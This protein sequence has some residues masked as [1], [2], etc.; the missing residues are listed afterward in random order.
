MPPNPA[1][2][3]SRSTSKVCSVTAPAAFRRN[4]YLAST[5]GMPTGSYTKIVR[6]FI[7]QTTTANNLL[8][9]A[10]PGTSAARAHGLLFGT[11]QKT[12]KLSHT[13]NFATATT[14]SRSGQAT[15][16]LATYDAT[17]HRGEIYLDGVFAGAGT[18]DGDN[19]LTSYQVGALGAPPASSVPFRSGDLRPRADHGRTPG[20]LRLL[21]DKYR[22]Q[23][24]RWQKQWFAAGDPRGMPG[25]TRAA[26][27]S[28]TRS[29]TRSTSI[30][31]RQLRSDRLLRV[32]RAGQT[33]EVSYRRATDRPDV[34]CRLE[35][36]PDLR[37]G[38]ESR[39]TSLGVAGS[40]DTRIY[41]VE[42]PSGP[43]RSSCAWRAPARV[44]VRPATACRAATGDRPSR[45]RWDDFSRSRRRTASESAPWLPPITDRAPHAGG[46]ALPCL[47]Q[48]V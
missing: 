35:S 16:A 4:H 18:A 15:L 12:L 27:A 8:S 1:P 43:V 26:T 36:S 30:P 39:I 10:S 17:T 6:F 41:T 33:V 3:A 23:F 40:I 28:P 19:T 5:N 46:G 34:V 7:S 32:R 20:H 14:E 31:G 9:G 24:Q 38:H 29:N 45:A 37:P 25:S 48:A 42:A 44:R 47:A 21:D 2:C 11:G 13:G 22:T